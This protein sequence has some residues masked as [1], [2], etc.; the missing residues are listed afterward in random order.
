[1]QAKDEKKKQ[2][3]A[4]EETDLLI[5]APVFAPLDTAESVFDR[6]KTFG[7]INSQSSVFDQRARFKTNATGEG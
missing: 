7:G 2:P 1:M 3:G 6:G 4:D 5:E